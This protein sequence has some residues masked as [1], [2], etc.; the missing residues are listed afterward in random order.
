M[1]EYKIGQIRN[2]LEVLSKDNKPNILFLSDDMRMSSGIATMSRE[3]V[4]GTCHRFN[5][6]QIG[7]A[8]KHPEQGKI[9]DLSEDISKNTG[10]EDVLVKV[11]PWS[12]YG[13]ANLLRQLLNTENLSAILHFTDPR[14]FTW[15]YDIEHE[16]REQ[17]PILY[18]NIWDNTP[19]PRWNGN[20]YASCDGLFAISKQT[21]GI[22]NRIIKSQFDDELD[23]EII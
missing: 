4:M 17:C 13:D 12:G 7:A 3:L 2:G 16:I 20:Y 19:D 23:I 1:T 15:L 14:Y 11:I 9:I 18:Y 6:T 8:I 10:V 21:F 5:F 22:N